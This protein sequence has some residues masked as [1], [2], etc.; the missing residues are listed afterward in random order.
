PHTPSF[1]PPPPSHFGSSTPTSPRTPSSPTI[2]LTSTVPNTH[3]TSV[4]SNDE[5]QLT[6]DVSD[7]SSVGLSPSEEVDL[8]PLSSP[9]AIDQPMS[10]RRAKR[11]R[12]K[13]VRLHAFTVDQASRTLLSFV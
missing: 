3:S 6:D 4:P 10:K 9:A 5:L 1:F 12:Y 7:T 2:D 13:S 11:L 8:D